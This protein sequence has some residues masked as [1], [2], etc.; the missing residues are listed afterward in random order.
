MH[1]LSRHIPT[2]LGDMLAVASPQGLCLLEFVGQ[3]GVERELAQVQVARGGLPPQH[4][5]SAVLEQTAQELGE[6]FAGQRQRFGVP[7]DLVGT[8]FQCRAWQ[9]LLA[10]PFGQT[11]SY[12]EQARAI[13][14]PTATRAVAAANGSNKISIV[15]PCHRVIGSDGSLTGFGGGLPRKRAL[16][17]LEN[18]AGQRD[19]LLES[20]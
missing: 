13:G 3:Q 9:A 5:S 20:Q 11:R 18:P 8:P 10:I 1:L 17:A 14:Q 4:G 19:W 6:Y 12:A 2:P 15:V 7:L 16:L